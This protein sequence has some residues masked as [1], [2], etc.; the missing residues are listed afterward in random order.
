MRSG[1]PTAALPTA[2]GGVAP[3]SNGTRWARLLTVAALGAGLACTGCTIQLVRP[4][5]EPQVLEQR[6]AFYEWLHENGVT[7]AD[8]TLARAGARSLLG[9]DP[10]Q[11]GEERE[12]QAEGQAERELRAALVHR[13]SELLEGDGGR[14]DAAEPDER[15]R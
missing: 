13:F 1:N 3:A 8:P 15:G 12:E 5:T 10:D 6:V 9:L 11:G 14:H 4:S 2:A 7:Q